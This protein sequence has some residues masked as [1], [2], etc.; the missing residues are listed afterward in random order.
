MNDSSEEIAT[1]GIGRG[2]WNRRYGDKIAHGTRDFIM[3][4]AA[5]R[6]VTFKIYFKFSDIHELDRNRPITKRQGIGLGKI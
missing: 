1:T 3:P 2:A 4:I 6:L 5:K